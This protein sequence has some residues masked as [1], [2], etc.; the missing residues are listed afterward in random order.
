MLPEL[1]FVCDIAKGI[2]RLSLLLL[3]HIH[4]TCPVVLFHLSVELPT[5]QTFSA[6]AVPHEME[7][8]H[9]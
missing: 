2:R 5:A 3:I 9:V 1:D 4:L 6:T 8:T 7:Y